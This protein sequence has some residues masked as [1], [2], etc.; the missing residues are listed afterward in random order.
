[1]IYPKLGDRGFTWA[2]PGPRSTPRVGTASGPGSKKDKQEYLCMCCVLCMLYVIMAECGECG[3]VE[4]RNLGRRRRRGESDTHHLST[5]KPGGASA[6]KA[7]MI[8]ARGTK[9]F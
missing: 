4:S 1:M 5:A 3:Q 7:A 8:F 6:D 2:L 9:H